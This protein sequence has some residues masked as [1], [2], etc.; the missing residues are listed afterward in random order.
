MCVFVF[1]WE[2]KWSE[3]S[4]LEW[5][6]TSVAKHWNFEQQIVSFAEHFDKIQ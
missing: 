4:R 1:D 3:N 6:W 5:Y 2:G